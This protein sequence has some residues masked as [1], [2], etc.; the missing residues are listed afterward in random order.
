MSDPAELIAWTRLRHAILSTAALLTRQSRAALVRD[1]Y[2]SIWPCGLL[3]RPAIDAIR[4]A[5]A[6]EDVSRGTVAVRGGRFGVGW[7]TGFE[8]A[9]GA[10]MVIGDREDPR[11]GPREQ[12]LLVALARRV[13]EAL[14]GIGDPDWMPPTARMVAL[15]DARSIRSTMASL[16]RAPMPHASLPRGHDLALSAVGVGVRGGQSWLVL[17]PAADG[18]RPLVAFEGQENRY[19]RFLASALGVGI[20]EMGGPLT[21]LQGHAELLLDLIPAN[22]DPRQSR[23]AS[24]IRSD[25]VRLG[26]T[27]ENLRGLARL[28]LGDIAVHATCRA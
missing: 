5:A 11:L 12:A 21:S 4:A 20:H 27:V 19:A 16:A 28:H 1:D 26:A 9:E 6:T 10:L 18:C 7:V 13:V 14:E 15:D 25:A 8:E 23:F 22:G 24:T 3:D 17:G 2:L